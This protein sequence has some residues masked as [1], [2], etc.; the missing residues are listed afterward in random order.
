MKKRLKA[1]WRETE[2]GQLRGKIR[3]ILNEVWGEKQMKK[4]DTENGEKQINKKY[5]INERR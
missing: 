1:I 3:E 4:A 5:K 2:Q